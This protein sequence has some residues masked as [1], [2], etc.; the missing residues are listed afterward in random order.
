MTIVVIIVVMNFGNRAR[1]CGKHLIRD[2]NGDLQDSMCL[3]PVDKRA[4]KTETQLFVAS[5]NAYLGSIFYPESPRTK[6]KW[7]AILYSFPRH[8][9]PELFYLG[10][11]WRGVEWGPRS[12]CCKASCVFAAPWNRHTATEVG[13]SCTSDLLL[14]YIPNEFQ[15]I[16]RNE[17]TRDWC[18]VIRG[19]VSRVP[20]FIDVVQPC[21]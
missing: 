5:K 21:V 13:G 6:I 11:N 4:E 16:S 7:V 8:E 20:A 1:N 2:R 18:Q 19:I 3:A 14:Q 12:L 15:G 10:A 9:A 17:D